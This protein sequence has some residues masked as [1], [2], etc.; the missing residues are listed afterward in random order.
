MR[1]A[2]AAAPGTAL[3]VLFDLPASREELR[4]AVAGAARRIAL[5]QPRQLA[6]LRALSLG[7]ALKPHHLPEASAASRARDASVRTSFVR[8]SIGRRIAASFCPSSRCSTNTTAPRSPRR[9][10]TA[11]ARTAAG[12][13]AP[14]RRSVRHRASDPAHAPRDNAGRGR[15]SACSSASARATACGRRTWSGRSRAK[16]AS[17]AATSGD[18]VRESH[19]TSRWRRACRSDHRSGV[20]HGGQRPS[21]APPPRQGPSAP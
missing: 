13:L 2:A 14:P 4:E 10:S 11:R 15:W 5:V 1:C 8:S 7:G 3:V 12:E 18:R 17:P 9:R 6:S 16:R 20:R 21:R 19:S